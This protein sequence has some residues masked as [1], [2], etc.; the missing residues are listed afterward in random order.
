[1]LSVYRKYLFSIFALFFVITTPFLIIYSLGYNLDFEDNGLQNTL[2]INIETYPRGVQIVNNK[3]NIGASP[4][5]LKASDGEAV[6]LKLE[7]KD[8][9]DENF[10][11]WSEAN[12]NTAAKIT[13]LGMLPIKSDTIFEPTDEIETYNIISPNLLL[14]K[15]KD[16]K[17]YIQHY[18][19]GGL[20]GKRDEIKTN[21]QAELNFENLKWEQLNDS[22]YWNIQE[23]LLVYKIENEWAMVDLKNYTFNI[24]S[25][26][27]TVDYQIFI[28]TTNGELWSLNL[29][30]NQLDFLDSGFNGLYKAQDPDNTW[31]W[32]Q[33][34]IY[35]FSK[36]YVEP[37]SFSFENELFSQNTQLEVK[38]LEIND[39]NYYTFSVSNVFQGLLFKV[40]SFLYYVPDFNKNVWYSV[41]NDAI[42]I[43]VNSNT[44]FWF[45]H[46]KTLFSYNF[47]LKEQENFGILDG[48]DGDLEKAKIYYFYPWRRIFIY[49]D[50]NDVVSVWFDKDNLNRNIVKYSR[51]TWVDDQRCLPKV[52]DRIQYCISGKKLLVYKNTSLW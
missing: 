5:E 47:F 43:G 8:Y 16:Q 40:G 1:M 37:E 14:F 51:N 20:Q 4:L 21:I 13:N 7:K 23:N 27:P 19:L 18:N 11:L 28:L 34:K 24:K 2:S 52:V 41:A 31:L 25:L 17:F 30:T 6:S 32:R 10:T 36:D 49:S 48:V 22:L 15:A 38:G 26:A 33:D 3:F 45:D 39:P 44:V 9:L 12:T 29:R 50:T 46:N 35:R 42:S